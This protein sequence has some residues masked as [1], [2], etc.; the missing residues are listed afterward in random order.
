[1]DEVWGA[2]LILMNVGGC[3]WGFEV[4]FASELVGGWGLIKR[5]LSINEG[6]GSE[7]DEAAPAGGAA[8]A[9]PERGALAWPSAP[10]STSTRWALLTLWPCHAWH[11][12]G[13]SEVPAAAIR[14][15]N[16]IR[17]ILENHNIRT[18]A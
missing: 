9:A 13:L 7:Y 18:P 17:R 11:G 16:N 15:N 5:C 6:G 14:G 4:V 10:T 3:E 1:V 2:R 8:A 12:R